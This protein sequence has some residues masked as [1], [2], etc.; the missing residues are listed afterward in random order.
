MPTSNAATRRQ[1]QFRAQRTASPV[2]NWQTPIRG[3]NEQEFEI[4]ST[5]AVDANGND[6]TRNGAPMPTFEEWLSR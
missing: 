1:A 4:F 2:S 3:T 6:S 5:F